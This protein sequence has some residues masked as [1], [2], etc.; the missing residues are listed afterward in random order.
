MKPSHIRVF[1]GLR[2]STGHVNHLQTAIRTSFED[3]RGILGAGKVYHGF[4]VTGSDNQ[5]T[6]QPGLAFDLQN[7]RIVCDEAIPQPVTFASGEDTKYVAIKYN[8]VEDG[9]VEGQPTLIFDSCSV[10]ISPARPEA[11]DNALVLARLVKTATG[12]SVEPPEEPAMHCPSAEVSK[13]HWPALRVKQGTIRLSGTRTD[14]NV[15]LNPE[16]LAEKELPID[17]VTSGVATHA[18]LS[19]DVTL[20]PAPGE[21]SVQ[22]HVDCVSHGEATVNDATVDQFSI[23]SWPPYDLSEGD[24]AR[25]FL[26]L[27]DE[28]KL[29]SFGNLYL[30]LSLGR[31][32]SGALKVSCVL[33]SAAELAS[34]AVQAIAVRKPSV[35]WRAQFGWK[36]LGVSAGK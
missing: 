21:T 29:D 16:I 4:T 36:A 24:V 8:Q 28:A 14:P 22:F 35:S 3:L 5:I 30:A 15:P 19:A 1:D 20:L 10:V 13:A 25:L 26:R 7:N 33:E 18:L 31:T 6:V 23:S 11:K 34:E 12:F 27:P 17:F 32:G 9:A 2:I